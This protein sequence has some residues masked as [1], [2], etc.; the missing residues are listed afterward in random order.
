MAY[1]AIESFN[2]VVLARPLTNITQQKE[3]RLLNA[4]PGVLEDR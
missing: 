4:C 2:N 1:G 3:E